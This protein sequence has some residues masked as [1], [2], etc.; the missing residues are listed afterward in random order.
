MAFA[1][2][3][4]PTLASIRAIPGQFG[5][6]PHAVALVTGFS[7]GDH[8]GDG[9]VLDEDLPITEGEYPP[10]VRWLKDEEIAVGALEN[11][12]IE[13]GPITPSFSTGGTALADIRGD[14]LERGETRFVRI[15]GPKH[16]DGA[17]YQI[18]R[19]TADR[20]MNYRIQAKPV[21]HT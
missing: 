15:T 17:L 19:I 13:I 1:D 7:T 3:F 9:D 18:T 8:T 16:P 11:G 14:A 10:K 12:S 2:D 5:L 20:A 4:L 21:S 6:R